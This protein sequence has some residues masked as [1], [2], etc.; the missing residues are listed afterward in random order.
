[1]TEAPRTEIELEDDAFLPDRA[2]V[3]VTPTFELSRLMVIGID[4]GNGDKLVW[5]AQVAPNAP[6]GPGWTPINDNGYGK[7]AGG[8]TTDGRVAVVAQTNGSPRTVH[9]ITEA[10]PV[11][12]QERWSAPV[13]LGLPQGLGGFVQFAMARDAGGRVEIFGVDDSGGNV[14]WIYQNP[15]KIV[16][17]TI[18]VV[19]PGQTEPITIT[20]YEPEP[21]DQPWSAWMPLAGSG[22]NALTACNTA[23]DRILLF[24]LKKGD[25]PQQPLLT[26]AQKDLTTL[27]PDQWTGWQRIDTPAI[28]LPASVPTATLDTN[29]AVNVFAVA[30][31]AEVAQR[32][33]S[34]GDGSHWDAW[35]RPGMI[36]QPVVGVVAALDG[37][38][39]IGLVAMD[40]SR[41]LYGNL[42]T[43]ADFQ[44]W[45]TWQP[46]NV[47]PDFGTLHM[48]YNADG[49]L[50]LF[51]LGGDSGKLW[52]LSQVALN[53]TAWDAG[54]TELAEGGLSHFTV[55]RDLTPPKAA[56]A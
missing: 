1:M 6:W 16:E 14:W 7:L 19:P 50:S 54:W 42:Q 9:Y 27:Q 3:D 53:S 28:G 26:N 49:R 5:R 29:G 47:A 13:D 46:I 45:N 32:R 12:G 10:E 35:C 56:G 17:K 36:G 15:P 2:A 44:Q 25:S 22:A 18:Q 33:Q 43:N 20:V 30:D 34:T 48:D 39:H 52:V 37:Q 55:V 31:L 40:E 8:A 38:N 23:D 11:D 4:A 51:L 21:P 24:A 41:R